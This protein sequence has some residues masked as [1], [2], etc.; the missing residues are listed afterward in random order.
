MVLAIDA[1]NYAASSLGIGE[2][3]LFSS[4]DWHLVI[5]LVLETSRQEFPHVADLDTEFA[6]SFIKCKLR[7]HLKYQRLKLQRTKQS[8]QEQVLFERLM[9]KLVL[10]IRL[11]LPSL[12]RNLKDRIW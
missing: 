10:I 1:Q 7:N 3:M 4:L 2:S 8:N 6:M 12:F 5:T 11:N 9:L